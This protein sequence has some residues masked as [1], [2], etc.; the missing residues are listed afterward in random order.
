MYYSG[1]DDMLTKKLKKNMTEYKAR[2]GSAVLN[3]Q[4]SF[5]TTSD[6]WHEFDTLSNC[7]LLRSRQR[8]Q[9]QKPGYVKRTTKRLRF[10]NDPQRKETFLAS[11][12]S[13][14]SNIEYELQ[15]GKRYQE[16]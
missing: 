4:Q 15:V 12:A 5:L 13:Y 2:H 14:N 1:G 10:T 3:Y 8:R 6:D 7:K 11:T 9:T 16:G